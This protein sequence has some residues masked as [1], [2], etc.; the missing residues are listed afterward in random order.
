MSEVHAQIK[1]STQSLNEM[2]ELY[3]ITKATARKWKTA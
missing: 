1:V 2:A 3:N